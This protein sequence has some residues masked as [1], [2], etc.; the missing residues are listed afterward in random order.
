[1]PALEREES[2]NC[3]NP[4]LDAYVRI[5]SVLT[6]I[7]SAEYVIYERVSDPPNLTQVYPPTGRATVDVDNLCPTGHK[8]GTGH[9][10]AEWDVPVD[11]LV[12]AYEI[13]WFWRLT[14]AHAEQQFCQ[15]FVVTLQASMV[16]PPGYC[17]IQ[18]IRD[19]GVTEAMHDDTR[20]ESAIATA[21]RLIDMYTKRWFE[22]RSLT[23]TLD[24]LGVKSLHLDQPI[25]DVTELLVE[26][27]EV[28]VDTELIV[29]NRHLSENL[30]Q[31]DD[32][33]NPRIELLQPIEGSLEARLGFRNFPRGQR[34]VQITGQFGYTEYDGTA[35][36]KVPELI[37]HAC[38][39][40]AMR[41]LPLLVDGDDREDARARWRVT[42][43]KTRD[44]TIK[45]GGVSATSGG[46]A[47]V[48]AYTGD[49]EIDAILARFRRPIKI[50]A[51]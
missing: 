41:E 25:I 47:V 1:M 44:Q 26:D 7:Y 37:A 9:Y 2:S 31:P 40:M 38:K 4:V 13:H 8:I 39:L 23:F 6:D 45:L 33:E 11:A 32:R 50:R 24:G 22:P 21:S 29:Y 10:V 17:T 34:N 5:G 20:V 49:P 15:E 48:G 30:T 16:S 27:I 28:D 14:V 36:G 12:G 43:Y 42:E 19:E 46:R 35:T 51:V 3:S 18:D